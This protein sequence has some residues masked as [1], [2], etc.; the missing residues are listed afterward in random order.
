MQITRQMRFNLH[1]ILQ[2]LDLMFIM[3]SHFR[4]RGIFIFVL[5]IN[6]FSNLIQFY[7]FYLYLYKP[8]FLYPVRFSDLFPV[9]VEGPNVMGREGSMPGRGTVGR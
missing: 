8:F 3:A 1:L 7:Y 6:Y 5:R 9:N 4:F 2:M